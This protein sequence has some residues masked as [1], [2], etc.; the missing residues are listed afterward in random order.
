MGPIVPKSAAKGYGFLAPGAA[1][2]Q[3]ELAR[4]R[5]IAYDGPLASPP[6]PG[7]RPREM[8]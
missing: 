1:A 6:D 2:V 5:E 8:A 7:L 4:K 3:Y